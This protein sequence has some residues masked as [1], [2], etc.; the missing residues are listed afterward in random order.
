MRGQYFDQR[1]RRYM[2]LPRS[3]DAIMNLFDEMREKILDL[4]DRIEQLE[5][6]P[7]DSDPTGSFRDIEARLE[8]LESRA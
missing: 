2:P 1:T 5:N 7:M 4:E 6:P 3:T 8:E